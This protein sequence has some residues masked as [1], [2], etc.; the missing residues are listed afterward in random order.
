MLRI[1][2]LAL[3]FALV[4]GIA[5]S[6]NATS[7][8]YT[9]DVSGGSIS[10][11]PVS[12]VVIMEMGGG[13]TNFHFGFT[14]NPTGQ[15]TLTH[16]VSFEPTS[17]LILGLDVPT[18]VDGKT[19]LVFFADPTFIQNALGK[20]FSVSFPNTR[21]PDV[22]INLLAA[23]GGNTAALDWL[24][25]FF[26]GD[27]AAAAFASGGPNLGAEFSTPVLFTPEPST[28]VLFGLGGAML[29]FRLRRAKR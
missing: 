4:V 5:A 20:K 28:F 24:A 27:G 8:S 18:E 15:T 23:E 19:H 2:T 21:Y 6:A 1:R 25:K 26:A 11:N 16:D 9:V 14:L 12:H 13:F 22:A 7:I 10:G 3:S 17:T 29:A